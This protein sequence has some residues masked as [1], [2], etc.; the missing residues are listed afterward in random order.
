[1]PAVYAVLSAQLAAQARECKHGHTSSIQSI[2]HPIEP[3][4][5]LGLPVLTLPYLKR[6]HTSHLIHQKVSTAWCVMWHTL[7]GMYAI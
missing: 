2:M 3:Q 5:P 1:M 7:R 6:I 4:G